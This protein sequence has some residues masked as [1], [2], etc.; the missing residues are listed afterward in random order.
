[1][2]GVVDDVGGGELDDG[3][4]LSG[5]FVPSS[6]VALA[7]PVGRMAQ[8]TAHLHHQSVAKHEVDPC[9]PWAVAAHDH[10]APRA[11]KASV[12]DESQEPPLKKRL[13]SRIEEQFAHQ[14]TSVA[15]LPA[16]RCESSVEPRHCRRP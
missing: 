11:R 9:H 16:E 2:G 12:A 7:V 5:E 15:T 6:C 1:M 13:S 8:A 4:T 10:L 3:V 14:G